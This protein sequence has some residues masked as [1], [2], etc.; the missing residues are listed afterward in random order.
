[1]RLKSLG[2]LFL[3]G[4][5]ALL[6]PQ[7]AQAAGT[8]V[9]TSITN[10]A[11]LTYDV[12]GTPQTK[13]GDA[14]PFNVA[15]K[16]N[17]TVTTTNT[18]FVTLTP[19]VSHATN[20]G[21]LTFKVSNEGNTVQDFLLTGVAKGNALWD[22]LFDDRTGSGTDNFDPASYDIYVADATNPAVFD[23]AHAAIADYVD[24]L[25]PGAFKYVYVVIKGA[26]AVSLAQADGSVAVYSLYANAAVGDDPGVKGAEVDNTSTVTCPVGAAAPVVLADLVNGTDDGA[27][28]GAD[29]A[30]S[31]FKVVSSQL[32]ITKTATTIWDPINYDASDASLPKAIPGALVRYVVTV[33]NDAAASASASL[34]SIGDTLMG[35][36][37]LDQDL[38]TV[39]LATDT[40]TPESGVG[41][42]FKAK[43]AGVNPGDC[44]RVGDGGNGLVADTDHYYTYNTADGVI[45]AGQA[46]TATLATLLPADLGGGTPYVAGEL[47]PGESFTLTFNVYIQ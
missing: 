32:T 15:S 41:L 24:E 5:L 13:A 35:N 33:T 34:T 26:P 6:A 19:G 14:E 43:V 16:V 18:D 4:T 28:D 39:A 20:A 3:A 8:N 10:R 2:A 23:S 25:A 46:I 31:A 27:K 9:C 45:I 37:D 12:G 17:L 38:K 30:R 21:V 42:A 29:S 11:T 7:W 36:L 1:M 47:K 44:K 22:N 40:P